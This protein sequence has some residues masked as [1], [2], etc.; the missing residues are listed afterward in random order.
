MPTNCRPTMTLGVFTQLIHAPSDST[1]G[2]VLSSVGAL[3]TMHIW[4]CTLVVLQ[5]TSL[6]LT[7]EETLA[8]REQAKVQCTGSFICPFIHPMTFIEHPLWHIGY[9][10]EHTEQVPLSLWSFHKL[11]PSPSVCFSC[12]WERKD[13]SPWTEP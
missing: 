1:D 7:C 12:M 5:G 13:P 4:P 2:H 9:S 8:H 3:F 10:D 11:L 6:Q